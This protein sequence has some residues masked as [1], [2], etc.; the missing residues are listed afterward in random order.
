MLLVLR[1]VT[2]NNVGMVFAFYFVK[3]KKS[4]ELRQFGFSRDLSIKVSTMLLLFQ[5]AYATAV[6]FTAA[7]LTSTIY[8]MYSGDKASLTQPV[9]TIQD[10]IRTVL[11][12]ALA[13][14]WMLA[15]ATV[16]TKR[17]GSL[18]N[19]LFVAGISLSW[20]WGLCFGIILITIAEKMPS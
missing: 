4:P 10:G 9:E 8:A 5:I 18:S 12:S 14:P 6:G 19:G 3:A 16:N 11:L 7:G 1:Q 13:G 15:A 17:T 20:F 2:L